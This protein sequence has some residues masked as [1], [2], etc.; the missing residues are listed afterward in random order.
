MI[1]DHS[2]T[3]GKNG[4]GAVRVGLPIKV[5]GKGYQL[6]AH[7]GRASQVLLVDLKS[8]DSTVMY[9]TSNRHGQGQCGPVDIFISFGVDAVICHNL[10]L[11]AHHRLSETSIEIF[12]TDLDSVDEALAAFRS[13]VLKTFPVADVCSNHHHHCD[14]FHV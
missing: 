10:G 1:F 2:R 9:N 4:S 13:G 5:D 6:S 8:C 14:A 7:F 12:H 3:K 11:G